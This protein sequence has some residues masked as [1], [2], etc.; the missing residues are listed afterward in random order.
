MASKDVHEI[1]EKLYNEYKDQGYVSYQS[2]YNDD[3]II[4]L[5]LDK[6]VYVCD[7]LH[8]KGVIFYDASEEKS[9]DD[10]NVYDYSRTKWEELFQEVV[11]SDKSLIPFINEVRQINPPQRREFTKW[12]HQVKNGNSFAREYIIK[13]YLRTAIKI[14]F[15]YHQKYRTPLDETIQEACIGL[16]IA[17]DHYEVGMQQKFPTYASMWIRQNIGRNAPMFNPLIPI[18]DYIK[19][20]LISIYDILEKF[21]FESCPEMLEEV[22]E[23]LSCSVNEAGEY[24]NYLNQIENIDEL[25]ENNESVFSDCCTFEE[26][27]L[28]YFNKEEL[29]SMVEK[30][31]ETL[32][33]DEKKV[34]LFRFL[35]GEECALEEVG[36]LLGVTRERIR[37]IEKKRWKS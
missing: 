29:K 20:K 24:A 34:I 23:K 30:I 13:R 17:L 7:Y 36:N 27:I 4:Q 15:Q 5:P 35:N 16:V 33:P 11:A 32:K 9:D 28:N 10:E 18:P 3:A 21:N 31:L 12:I 22:S 26:Q 19:D 37:Q 1:I 14:A 25:L 6:R 2:V 8:L